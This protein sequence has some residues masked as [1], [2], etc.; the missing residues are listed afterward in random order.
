[1]EESIPSLD[2]NSPPW[3]LMY[4]WRNSVRTLFEI[5][6]ALE[7]LQ[8]DEGFRSS[9]LAQPRHFQEAFNELVQKIRTAHELL[10]DIRNEISGHVKLQAVQEALTTMDM[11]SNGLIEL[12]PVISE[13]HYQFASQLVGQILLRDVPTAN[14]ESHLEK[15]LGKTAALSAALE[16]IDIVLVAYRDTKRL[17]D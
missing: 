15:T 10:K 5:R 1:M 8:G 16:A 6:S 3:R 13:S 14:W 2:K 11:D 12:G 7:A 4:F 9:L 17:W